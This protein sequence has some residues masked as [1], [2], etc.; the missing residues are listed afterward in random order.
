MVRLFATT[1]HSISILLR[2]KVEHHT[3]RTNGN[4]RLDLKSNNSTRNYFSTEYLI[5]IFNH[6]N[7]VFEMVALQTIAAA[8][9]VYLLP[10]AAKSFIIRNVD[11]RKYHHISWPLYQN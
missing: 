2:N 6:C 10:R 7:N 4:H 9:A 11:T 3:Q 1:K 5:S 8:L